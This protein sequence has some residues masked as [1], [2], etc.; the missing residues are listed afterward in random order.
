MAPHFSGSNR[1]GKRILVYRFKS[2]KRKKSNRKMEED[3]EN[4]RQEIAN[5]EEK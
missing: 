1:V 3:A 2:I 4:I 5:G